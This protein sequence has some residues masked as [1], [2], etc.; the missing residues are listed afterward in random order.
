MKFRKIL[1]L[2]LLAFI[3]TACTNTKKEEAETTDA[4][5]VTP[6]PQP[7]N[8]LSESERS[9]GWELLFDGKTSHGWRGFKK[10]AF[11]AEGWHVVDGSLMIEYSGTGE[12]G[13]A[14][15]VITVQEFENFELSID[16]KISEG[17]N[18]GI[19]F[20]VTESDSYQAS[21][22]TAHEIQVL[23]DFG[24]DD[25]HDYVPNLR[26]ISGALYDLYT[27]SRAASKPVGEWNTA[28]IKIKNGHLQHWLNGIQVLDLQLWSEHWKERVAGSKFSE[29][30]DFGLA[31]RGSIGLQDHGQQ[32]WFRNIKIREL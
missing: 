11:P 6:E 24:Y 10:E 28:R 27:P 2:M 5:I 23:D 16:W 14:G 12:K 9:A 19:L 3:S 22:H 26:Q 8:T 15:D 13:F 32:V 30:P 1:A 20:Y 18:S 17:G 25:I 7:I 4:S 29:Y 31:R 21:W